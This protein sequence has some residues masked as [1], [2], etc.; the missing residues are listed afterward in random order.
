MN[1]VYRRKIKNRK[2]TINKKKTKWLWVW[3]Q[4]LIVLTIKKLLTAQLKKY[5]TQTSNKKIKKNKIEVID[6]N[7]HRYEEANLKELERWEDN[8]IYE[9]VEN[10]D[11]KRI[12]VR[13]VCSVKQTDKGSKLKARLAACGFKEDSLDTF[14]R[15]SPT[16]SKDTLRALLSNIITNTWNLKSRDGKIAFPQGEFLKWDVCLKP[17]PEAH[18]DNNQI[19]KL[20]KCMYGL[21]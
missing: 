4:M 12:S 21:N 17:P 1:I 3:V 16:V 6:I 18:C 15:E 2:K 9:T 5:W 20:N 13:W 14:D 19:W 8:N 10:Q 11:Q 7:I